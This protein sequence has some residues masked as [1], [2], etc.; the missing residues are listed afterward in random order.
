MISKYVLLM[1]DSLP[2]F[3]W[4]GIV[5]INFSF[6][7]C[8]VN[9][10]SISLTWTVARFRNVQSVHEPRQQSNQTFRKNKLFN[11]N[12]KNRTITPFDYYNYIR[13]G[14]WIW[15]HHLFLKRFMNKVAN[16]LK[17][18]SSSKN[19]KKIIYI[20]NLCIK[21][22]YTFSVVVNFQIIIRIYKNFF[23]E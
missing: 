23:F 1:P 11:R 22:I 6:S 4:M 5:S 20:H 7:S 21:K 15:K 16:A 10:S 18:S 14:N 9:K 19:S 8:S 12:H 2:S 3:G 17:E 13:T